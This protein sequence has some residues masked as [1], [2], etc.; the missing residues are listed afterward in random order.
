M[1]DEEDMEL[2]LQVDQKPPP[3]LTASPTMRV[4]LSPTSGLANPLSLP[5]NRTLPYVTHLVSVGG[6]SG[7]VAAGFSSPEDTIATFNIGR[8]KLEKDREWFG[9]EG[10]ITCVLGSKE[11]RFGASVI[12]SCGKDGVVRSWDVRS[13]SVGVVFQGEEGPM[14]MTPYRSIICYTNIPTCAR[15]QP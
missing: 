6:A 8:G 7:V 2:Y 14:H 15:V 1:A 5:P 10:G 13:G 12:G 3:S 9:H 4:A 11:G